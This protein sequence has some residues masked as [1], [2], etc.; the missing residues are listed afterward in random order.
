MIAY[1]LA[2][3][4]G[5]IIGAFISSW[6]FPDITQLDLTSYGIYQ[7]IPVWFGQ[8]LGIGIAQFILLQ[9][10]Y[11]MPF[12]FVVGSTVGIVLPYEIPDIVF[13]I[14]EFNIPHYTEAFIEL[15][16]VGFFSNLLTG[17]LLISLKRTQLSIQEHAAYR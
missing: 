15:A 11:Q 13:P 14:V 8:G 9:S 6:I 17:V 1:V 10:E 5:Y 7:L 4:I 3:A 16:T 2:M 12:L